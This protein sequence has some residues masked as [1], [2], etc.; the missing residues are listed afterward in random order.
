MKINHGKKIKYCCYTSSS[1]GG[2]VGESKKTDLNKK[3]IS[4]L[5]KLE[6]L[7]MIFQLKEVP[8]IQSLKFSTSSSNKVEEPELL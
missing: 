8:C 5:L 3:S 2:D 1:G 6:T 7:Q 4:F